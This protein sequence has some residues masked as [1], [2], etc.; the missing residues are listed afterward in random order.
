M[1]ITVHSVMPNR[2]LKVAQ[3]EAMMLSEV[4]TQLMIL[5]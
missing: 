3:P 1:F 4:H 2:G 5:P